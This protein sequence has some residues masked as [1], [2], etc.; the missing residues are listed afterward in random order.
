[1]VEIVT[2]TI[3]AMAAA[4]TEAVEAAA[5]IGITLVEGEVVT[6]MEGVGTEVTEAA[7]TEIME[8]VVTEITEEAETEI[9]EQVVI[10]KNMQVAEAAIKNMRVAEDA[11]KNMQVEAV[12]IKSTE[13]V[14]K[15]VVVATGVPMQTHRRHCL[16]IPAGSKMIPLNHMIIMTGC[17]FCRETNV[18]KKSYSVLEIPELIL[19][20]TK[21]YRWMPLVKIFLLT[22]Q[23]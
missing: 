5:A 16:V 23:R 9:M 2:G 17:F 15:A 13:V 1:M 12:V 3:I 11:I 22:L 21:I 20:S 8:E 4:N 10:K 14:V 18:W 19:T 7:V 6:I